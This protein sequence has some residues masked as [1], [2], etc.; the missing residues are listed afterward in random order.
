MKVGLA[1][2]KNVI[3]PLPK[4]VLIPLGLKVPVSGRDS[5]EI[6]LTR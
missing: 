5:N 4:S 6:F 2:R 3:E 1:L